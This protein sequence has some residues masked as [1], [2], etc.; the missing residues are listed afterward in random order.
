[1]KCP[2][3]GYEIKETV[4]SPIHAWNYAEEKILNVLKDR[5]E[6]TYG[7]ILT[8]S[9][10]SKATLTKHLKRLQTKDMIKKR[11]DLESRIYPYPVFYSMK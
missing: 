3:C 6:H 10:V 1:M 9:I 4:S 8:Q 7:D 11:I 5:C 2:N